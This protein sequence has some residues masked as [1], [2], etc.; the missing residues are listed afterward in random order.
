MSQIQIHYDR[1][2][3]ETQTMLELREDVIRQGRAPVSAAALRWT[4]ET[5]DG[6]RPLL[7]LA[8]Y[9][10]AD[11]V[12]LRRTVEEIERM[13]DDILLERAGVLHS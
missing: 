11:A 13:P 12:I 1:I 3:P 9:S 2:D 4:V 8:E 6:E 7:V 10:R 5:D